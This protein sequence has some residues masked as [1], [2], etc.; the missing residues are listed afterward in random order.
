[1]KTTEK[2][3]FHLKNDLGISKATIW[4]SYENDAEH[5][6]SNE[7][8]ER[9]F[10]EV[11]RLLDKRTQ[12]YTKDE[13]LVLVGCYMSSHDFCVLDNHYD[14]LPIEVYQANEKHDRLEKA[15]EILG[16]KL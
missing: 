16:D 6:P 1:M 3:L 12:M 8:T 15:L 9:G 14:F 2:K 7:H 4:K 5:L 10:D 11:R 13:S